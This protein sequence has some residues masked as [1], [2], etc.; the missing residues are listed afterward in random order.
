M[1]AQFGEYG[2]D[3]EKTTLPDYSLSSRFPQIFQTL[4]EKEADDGLRDLFTELFEVGFIFYFMDLLRN[5]PNSDVPPLPVHLDVTHIM[6]L[7]EN[8]VQNIKMSWFKHIEDIAE[9]PGHIYTINKGYKW[10]DRKVLNAYSD[11]KLKPF[12]KVHGVK[13]GFLGKNHRVLFHQAKW[14]FFSG[15][16]LPA[17]YDSVSQ[18]ASES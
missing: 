9:N 13:S 10:V 8:I 18:T 7:E 6:D 1:N 15:L 17:I 11:I 3:I 2:E 12:Y 16:L 5:L 14:V 4:Q